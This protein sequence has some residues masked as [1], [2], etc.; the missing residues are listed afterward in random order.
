L[1]ASTSAVM[2]S[3]FY[4]RAHRGSDHTAHA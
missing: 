2:D 3:S 4:R 1:K